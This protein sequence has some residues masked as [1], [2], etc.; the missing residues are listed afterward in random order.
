MNPLVTIIIPTYNRADLIGETLHSVLNQTHKN[1]E[2]IIV[3]D[4]SSDNTF[5]LVN[6]FVKNDDRFV[7]ILKAESYHSGASSSRNIGLINAKGDFIQFLDSDDIL[8]SN[9]LEAQ[10]HLLQNQSKF[11]LV[12]CKWGF[13]ERT[14]KYFEVFKEKSDFRNFENIKDYFDL[15][16]R[17]GGFFPCHVFL[18][19]KVLAEKVGFWNESISM[20]DDG[21]FFFRILS[22]ADQIIFSPET[23]VLY[24]QG[25]GA[26]LSALNSLIKANDLVESW[27]I[28]ELLYC[29]KYGEI[30]SL[31]LTR[32]K[33]NVYNELKSLFP[34]VIEQNKVFFKKEISEDTLKLKL[35]KFKKRIIVKLKFIFKKN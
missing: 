20:N 29:E 32:K 22:N 15:I 33:G 12:T 26:N 14:D 31:Y 24:R 5:F 30:N 34:K 16:G 19:H 11:S 21:E 10:L 35:K 7:Y 18:F 6:E 4:N 2:C 23:F 9:K 28:I 3:D 8:A 25:N 1:W 27:K 13:F 17:D